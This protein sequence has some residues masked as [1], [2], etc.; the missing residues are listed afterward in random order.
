MNELD[1]WLLSTAPELV[2]QAVLGPAMEAPELGGS[3]VRKLESQGRR[4][5]RAIG[6]L[7]GTTLGTAL[8]SKGKGVGSVVTRL[9][10]SVVGGNVLGGMGGAALGQRKGRKDVA[11]VMKSREGRAYMKERGGLQE[12]RRALLA[13]SGTDK[14]VSAQQKRF[15]AARAL[16]QEALAKESAEKTA[17]S[18]GQPMLAAPVQLDPYEQARSHGLAEAGAHK[19]NKS[20]GRALGLLGGM[21]VGGLAKGRVGAAIGALG[22]VLGGHGIG[23]MVRGRPT[24][25]DLR[26][27][28][29]RARIR[30][31]NQLYRQG[32]IGRLQRRAT[33][34]DVVG[35]R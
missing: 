10:P 24:G 27:A 7:M 13:G 28:E 3:H 1:L 14:D 33:I 18:Y 17:Q 25:R 12:A 9:A 2:K 21:A 22:G 26:L 15:Q 30:K 19:R 5:G 8:A 23:S 32:H 31:A 16:A 6:T 4:G 34:Q 11:E 35:P 20:R 29:G